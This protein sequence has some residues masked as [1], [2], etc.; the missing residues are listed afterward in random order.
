MKKMARRLQRNTCKLRARNPNFLSLWRTL[1]QSWKYST[2]VFLRKTFAG[3]LLDFFCLP[4]KSTA[5]EIRSFEIPAGKRIFAEN[6]KCFSLWEL[7]ASPVTSLLQIARPWEVTTFSARSL[8]YLACPI[9]SQGLCSNWMHS[10]TQQ[11]TCSSLWSASSTGDEIKVNSSILQMM[12][13][14]NHTSCVIPIIWIPY[15][16]YSHDLALM[17]P[18]FRVKVAG[19]R[20]NFTRHQSYRQ[21][22][23]RLPKLSLRKTSVTKTSA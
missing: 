12:W 4:S 17:S 15:N 5:L 18:W 1:L 9:S 22:V 23:H 10:N 21:Q 14:C 13:L 3:L 11:Q 6:L 19:S 20:W 16:A 7:L 8:F 2:Y